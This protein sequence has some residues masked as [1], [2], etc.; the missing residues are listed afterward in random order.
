V[1]PRHRLVRR[2]GASPPDTLPVVH[3][4]RS[5]RGA[6]AGVVASRSPASVTGPPLPSRVGPVRLL[7]HARRWPV[8]GRALA[9]GLRCQVHS[10]GPSLS[11]VISRLTVRPSRRRFAA[12]LNSVVRRVRASGSCCAASI[13]FVR[14]HCPV[15]LRLHRRARAWSAGRHGWLRGPGR[16]ADTATPHPAFLRARCPCTFAGRAR[17]LPASA[18]SGLPGVSLSSHDRA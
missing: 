4:L 12:R 17:A 10:S 7:R 1:A 15:A 11:G 16:L 3:Q 18:A 13:R 6:R 9:P 8:A 5:V 2:L 14:N